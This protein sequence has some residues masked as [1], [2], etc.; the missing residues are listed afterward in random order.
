[1]LGI[2]GK[3][4][5]LLPLNPGGA[6]RQGATL[7]LLPGRSFR[8]FAKSDRAP[9][10]EAGAYLYCCFLHIASL[11]LLC[12]WTKPGTQLRLE[13]RIALAS[14]ADRSFPA[15][16]ASTFL[17]APAAIGKPE[18]TRR[19]PKNANANSRSRDLGYSSGSRLR[20]S[21][22]LAMAQSPML[23]LMTKPD[24]S[25][26]ERP[27]HSCRLHVSDSSRNSAAGARVTVRTI[28]G[29]EDYRAFPCKRPCC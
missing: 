21:G 23:P 10:I 13:H 3:I 11:T 8:E 29:S 28:P 19:R 4:E 17:S 18:Q 6:Q 5:G 12:S 14:P 22:D 15:R 2:D 7:D 1:M 25:A 26:T 27:L 16:P 24:S 9:A 20:D